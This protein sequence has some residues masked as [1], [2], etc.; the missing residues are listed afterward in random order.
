MELDLPHIPSSKSLKILEVA[1]GSQ[2]GEKNNDDDDDRTGEATKLDGSIH[3][4]IR[5]LRRSNTLTYT[6][7][8][9]SY[10]QT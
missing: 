7:N 1:N 4:S 9:Q 2:E 10:I 5:W 6:H 8:N 3:P